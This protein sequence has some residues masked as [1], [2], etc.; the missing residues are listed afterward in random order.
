MFTIGRVGK[1]APLLLAAPG[2]WQRS[3]RQITLTST[4]TVLPALAPLLRDQLL[5][6]I[7]NGDEQKVPVISTADPRLTGY[8]RIVDVDIDTDPDLI[9]NGSVAARITLE[10]VSGFTQPMLEGVVPGTL[11]TNAVGGVFADGIAFHAV[12]GA[13][14]EYN[15]NDWLGLFNSYTRASADGPIAVFTYGFHDIFGG[16]Y[17]GTTVSARHAVPP[18]SFYVGAATL[19][20]GNPLYPVVGRDLV[21]PDVANWRLSNGLVRVTPNAIASRLDISHYNGSIWSTKTYTLKDGAAPLVTGWNS[22]TVLRNSVEET[23]IRLTS[24]VGMLDILSLDISLRRGDEIARL[25]FATTLS[26]GHNYAVARI[27]AEASTAVAVGAITKGMIRATSNDADGNRFVIFSVQN[28]NPTNDLVNGAVTNTASP[29][30]ADFGIG[31][32][33]GG[34]GSAVPNRAVDLGGQYL[35]AQDETQRVV[36][37]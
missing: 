28:A 31:S 11:L 15:A 21:Q 2:A 8:Y 25:Y 20:Q 9:S 5:G 4:S 22:L 26:N 18:A 30:A 19:E 13:S 32:E 14:T 10:M 1:T 17:Y 37:R 27:T 7:E 36:A 16:T 3:G 6:Y 34:S 35:A 24:G 29:M 33:I 12:P 23:I